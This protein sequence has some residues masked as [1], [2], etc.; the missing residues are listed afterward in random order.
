VP[1]S[2]NDS[3]DNRG[4]DWMAV[5]RTLLVQ[6][7][8]LIALA[9]AFIGY[10]NWSSDAAFEEFVAAS[11]PAVADPT[12]RLQSATQVLTVKGKAPCA[13]KS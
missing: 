9:G 2:D 13:P 6:I 10:I 11:K 3:P 5:A 4:I 8:V 1:T 7:L 12:P